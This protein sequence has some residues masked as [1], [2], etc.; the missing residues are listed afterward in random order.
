MGLLSRG[1]ERKLAGAHRGLVELLGELGGRE[2]ARRQLVALG[3]EAVP[4]L[5]AG[6]ADDQWLVRDW[7]A[8]ILG[9]LKDPRALE[10]L[11]DATR[12][13]HWCVVASAAEALGEIG[14]S[15]ASARLREL[16][17]YESSSPA[18]VGALGAAGVPVSATA[19]GEKAAME[20]DDVRKA[21]RAA[22]DK[23]AS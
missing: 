14:G 4:A 22:L 8:Q 9:E 13:P 17:G 16:A 21:A 7:A 10:P 6:L 1:R 15:A 19:A 3:P 5:I 11:L 18:V 23:L 20:T 2:E 12:D